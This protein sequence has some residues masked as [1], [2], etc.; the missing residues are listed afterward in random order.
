MN[1]DIE[2][3]LAEGRN[4][5]N[6]NH[7]VEQKQAI[8]PTTAAST[9]TKTCGRARDTNSS[10]DE[11]G[12]IR[13]EPTP[14][15][16]ANH[17]YK[18]IE[19]KQDTTTEAQEK[20]DRQLETRSAYGAL[21][22]EKPKSTIA[23]AEGPK[24]SP[25]SK[26]VSPRSTR[27]Y[28][29]AARGKPVYDSYVPRRDISFRD[30]DQERRMGGSISQTQQETIRQLRDRLFTTEQEVS[31]LRRETEMNVQQYGSQGLTRN[32]QAENGI[33]ENAE[34]ALI[35]SPNSCVDYPCFVCYL[36]W[37]YRHISQVFEVLSRQTSSLRFISSIGSKL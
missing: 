28:P 29:M 22:K 20:L 23:P 18:S 36:S 12:E 19:S 5:A 3:L 21:K 35:V 34:A 25:K 8:D 15:S 14:P 24:K 9:A 7:Q 27:E 17:L 16:S 26:P 31:D 13:G 33:G 37:S 4:A 6:G 30:N 32:P 10:S 11:E 1:A 2:S